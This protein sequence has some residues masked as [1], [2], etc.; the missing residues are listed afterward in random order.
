VRFFLFDR[1]VLAERGKRMVA[2]KLVDLMDDF[3]SDHFSLRPV[4][5]ATM[6]MEALAQT[7]G[8]LNN[9][10]HDFA[11][12]M[13]LILMDGVRLHRTVRP[14]DVLTLTAQMVYD[15]PYGATLSGEARVDQQLVAS[16]ERIAFAHSAVTDPNLIR[17]N[18][19]RFDYQSGGFP[20]ARE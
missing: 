17:S 8:M 7:S 13:V 19:E 10:N 2:I 20:A 1:I 16:A 14:G 9:L 4:M 11:V 5:P 6:V 15:H 18:R 12:E 3:F